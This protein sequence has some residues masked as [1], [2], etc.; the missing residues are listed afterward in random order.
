MGNNLS[1]QNQNID[2]KHLYTKLDNIASQ[3]ILSMN[4]SSLKN[5]H[6]KEYCD[7]LIVLTADI[8]NKNFNDLEIQNINNRI[9]NGGDDNFVFFNKDISKN[10]TKYFKN[11]M[12]ICSNIAKF[13]IKIAHLFSS[14][15]LAINPSYV[16]KDEYGNIIKKNFSEKHQIPA[17]K[18]NKNNHQI[19]NIN[20]CENRIQSLNKFNNLIQNNNNNNNKYESI[21]PT[22]C[23]IN[24]SNSNEVKSLDD[25]PGITELEKLYYDDEYDVS[26]GLFT[27]MSESSAQQYKEDLNLFYKTFT[28]NTDM[29]NITKFSE[30]KLK[31]YNKSEICSQNLE[32]NNNTNKQ[33]KLFEQYANNLKNM[34]HNANNYHHQLLKIIDNMFIEINGDFKINSDLTID[35]LQQYIINCRKILTNLYL[36][37]E[38]DFLIGFKLFETIIESKI[39]DTTKKQINNLEN[40]SQ[41]L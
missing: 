6:K 8:I 40:I 35:K 41:N 10:N 29:N 25:E 16:Y 13:Y 24:I 4:F 33:H 14:I 36:K 5:L 1:N 27:K 23:N 7:N 26:T 34:I 11:K 28:N 2:N 20:I 21:Y 37:C 39:L 9:H 31:D 3:Y 30:I 19:M 22:M 17:E 38:E 15:I 12:L 32:L 18:L